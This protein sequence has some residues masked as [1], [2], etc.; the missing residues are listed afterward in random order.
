MPE[1]RTPGVYIEEISS[2]PRPVQASST[3][4]TGFVG[5]VTLPAQFLSGRG[6]AAGLPLPIAEEQTLLGWNRALAFRPL[7]IDVDVAPPAAP[8]AGE[9][10]KKPAAAAKPAGPSNRLQKLVHEA[11][12]GTWTVA[13]PNGDSSVSL[14]S[15][16]GQALRVPLSRT[17]LA[18][19][20]DEKGNRVWDLAFG[21]DEQTV[22][23]TVASYAL[24]QDVRHAG[25]LRCAE[26]G[27][28]PQAIDVAAVQERLQKTAPGM[29]SMDAYEA[30]RID[31]GRNLFVQVFQEVDTTATP[32]KA[33]VAWEMLSYEARRAWD[34]WLRS[35]PG[36]RRLEIALRGFFENGGKTAFVAVGV[37]AHG[38]AGPGKRKFLEDSFDGVKAV[39]MICA[40][41]LDFAW[42]Q[43]ILEYAGPKGRGDL[44]AVLDTARYLLTKAP[45][46]AKVDKFRWTEGDSPY[47]VVNLETV[48]TAQL[49]E[50]R[51][52]GYSADEVL[53]RTIPR[54][55]TGFGAAYGPWLVVDNPLSTGP[56]DRFVIAPPSGHVAGVIAATDLKGG[57]GVHKAPANELVAGVA[58]VVTAISDREQE[59]L[60]MKSINIIRQRPGAGLRVWGA[61]TTASDALWRYVNVRRMFLFV[62]RS[63]RDAI[64]WAVF[65]P[66]SDRT[67]ADLRNTIAGFLYSLYTQG[68]LDGQ[69]WKDAFTVQ[70]NRENN[71][72]IDV[73]NGIMTVDVSIRPLFPAE[74]VRVRFRQSPAQSEVNEA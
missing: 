31:F 23:Q 24:M 32:A 60:N 65:L 29:S 1:Y 58:D 3:T 48:G 25:T 19:T 50:L 49:A 74:F 40:P 28:K 64:Q 68:M 33:D 18:V 13:P 69:T 42:Q 63:V 4:E 6:K 54:D 47:E 11:L 61:R 8:A 52:A 26:E 20:N 72:D 27:R 39:A 57:G 73:R 53:D 37:Q 21:A 56:H 62:E 70:C 51:F 16:K 10:P 2:G 35:H 44:F 15:D 22:L 14:T 12:P 45:R 38:A 41:G 5:M 34:T 30:W 66:N 9:D 17:L 43:S 55:D 46:A 7:A 36:I 67:R 71:P 59:S